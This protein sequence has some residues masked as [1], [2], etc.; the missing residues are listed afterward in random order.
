MEPDMLK[1]FDLV[2]VI[3][4]TTNSNTIILED[5]IDLSYRCSNQIETGSMIL[6]SLS[7]IS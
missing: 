4:V 7:H 3:Y 6:L 2:L 1:G 5:S